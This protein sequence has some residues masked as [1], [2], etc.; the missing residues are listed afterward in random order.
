MTSAAPAI[1]GLALALAACGNQREVA[2]N[3]S[4]VDITTDNGT[5]Q[6]STNGGTAIP[7]GFPP[8]P[9][10]E[11][12]AGPRLDVPGPAYKRLGSASFMTT[13]P[14]DQVIAFYRA[15]AAR[16]GHE[17]GMESAMGNGR[18]MGV[19]GKGGATGFLLTVSPI[20]GTGKT[21]VVLK[22]GPG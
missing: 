18:V 10:A 8:Y 15:A 13:D 9:G 2:A 3:D 12:D 6:I 22:G 20:A 1:I 7:G 4:V 17:I 11:P 16:M 5:A 21:R 14:P 19:A